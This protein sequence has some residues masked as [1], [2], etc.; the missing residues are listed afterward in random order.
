MTSDIHR[1]VSDLRRR[2][3][4]EGDD[5]LRLT[6]DGQV[7]Q[8][9]IAARVDGVC[10]QVGAALPGDDYATLV[11]LLAQLVHGMDVGP[12][13]ADRRRSHARRP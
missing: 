8:R 6:A 9:A 11:R 5:G 7:A 4:L 13:P 2:A 3:W 1:V 12:S 10:A